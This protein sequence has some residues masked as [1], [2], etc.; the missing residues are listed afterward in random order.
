[1]LLLLVQHS[2]SLLSSLDIIGPSRIGCACPGEVLSFICTVVGGTT[3]IWKGTAFDCPSAGNQIILR[4]SLFNNSQNTETLLCTDRLLVGQPLN[5]TGD[6]YVSELN[7]TV[8]DKVHNKTVQCFLNSD[9]AVPELIGTVTIIVISG[10]CIMIAIHKV[11]NLLNQYLKF[12][13]IST[14]KQ[15]QTSQC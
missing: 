6:C 5:V 1:M 11:W 4:H 10:T 8:T 12:R 2:S 3:T 14:T 9:V 7:A 15:H 13:S